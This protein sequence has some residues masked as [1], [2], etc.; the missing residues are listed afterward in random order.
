MLI[1]FLEVH[2]LLSSCAEILI[3][4]LITTLYWLSNA[5]FFVCVRLFV[6]ICSG[7]SFHKVT[8]ETQ[9]HLRTKLLLPGRKGD[10]V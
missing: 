5:D 10:S 8:L 6:F 7:S 3:F 1:H 2:L 4:T 9:C